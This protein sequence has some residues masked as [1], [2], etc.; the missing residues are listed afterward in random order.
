MR[1]ADTEHAATD[2]I[3]Q[4]VNDRARAREARDPWANLCVF[5]TV[6]EHRVPHA[7]VVVLRDLDERL[8]IFVN[9]TSP[10][11]DQLQHGARY[12]VLV[13]LA[14]LGVQYR[15]T[16]GL[17]AVAPET[18]H[19]NWRERPRIPKVMDWFYR[20]VQRQS[21]PIRSRQ[22]LLDAYAELDAELPHT[23]E[24]PLDAVGYFLVIDEI[25]RLELSGVQIHSRQHHRRRADG[26]LT[27]ELVP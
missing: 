5:A 22:H 19:R 12:S 14:S 17:E 9:A 25:E 7:R 2:P 11:H 27:N 21:T 6:N 13:Y 20:R 24:A 18:V 16:V 10:K 4:L 15:L 8:A 1:A 26:W 3:G 23:I